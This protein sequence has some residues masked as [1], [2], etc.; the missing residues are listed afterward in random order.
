M[1]HLTGSKN[2]CQGKTMLCSHRFTAQAPAVEH[3]LT[4]WP[5]NLAHL[6]LN[7]QHIFIFIVQ[8]EQ[9]KNGPISWDLPVLTGTFLTEKKTRF[10]KTNWDEMNRVEN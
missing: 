9:N 4:V 3:C 2:N 1:K 5:S 8:D 10:S 7:E 6:V